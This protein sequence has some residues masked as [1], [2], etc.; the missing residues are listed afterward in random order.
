MAAFP[1]ITPSSRSFTPGVYPQK[2]YRSLNGAVIKR[3]FGNSPYGA[4]LSL[5][6][7]NISDDNVVIL[8]NHYRTETAANRR[9]LL[10]TNVTAGMS[11]GL[12]TLANASVDN[13]WWEYEGAPEV[14]SVRPGRSTVTISLA[15]EIRNPQQDV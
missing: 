6:F 15:G 13:L 5:E 11:A 12:V 4:K 3:T 2:S 9:F 1:A 8:L 10:S 7:Q 14:T